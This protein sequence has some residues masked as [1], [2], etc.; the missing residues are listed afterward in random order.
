[1]YLIKLIVTSDLSSR[2]KG[3]LKIVKVDSK[4]TLIP[5]NMELN[6]LIPRIRVP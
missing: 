1:M 5:N 2:F 4:Q 6:G 3:T